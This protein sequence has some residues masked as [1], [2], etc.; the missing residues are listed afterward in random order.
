MTTAQESAETTALPRDLIEFLVELATTLHKYA[1]YPDGHPLLETAAQGVTKRLKPI[2]AEHPTFSLGIARDHILFEGMQSDLNNPVLRDL[3]VKFYR[4][5]IGGVRITEG[6]EDDELIEVMKQVGRDPK[7]G[8]AGAADA[9]L[10]H[11]WP[12]VTLLPLSYDALRLTDESPESTGEK[13]TWATQLW[14]RLAQ[15]GPKVGEVVVARLPKGPWTLQRNL[16]LLLG[17]LPEWPAG[18]SPAPYA[19]NPDARVRREAYALLLA[20]PKT[21]DKAV[22]DAIADT[23]ERITRAGLN[24]AAE[25]GCP[26]DAIAVLTR[27]LNDRSL[28]GMMGALAVKVLAPVR[29]TPVYECLVAVTL[30]PKRR[31]QLRRKLSPKSPIMLAALGVLASKWGAE[32]LTQKVLGIAARSDDPEIQ[33]ALRGKRS[34]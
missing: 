8:T 33:A 14:Q 1:M 26:R 5:E 29:L 3:A 13:G 9:S 15:L 30:A 12:H 7:A 16:L 10:A 4:R 24:A 2:L 22:A 20:D 18:F 27:R 21:R 23:D 32:P 31:F 19:K 25:H 17:R 11:E 28:D 34:E 6:V